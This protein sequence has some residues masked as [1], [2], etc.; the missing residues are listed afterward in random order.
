MNLPISLIILTLFITTCHA[1]NTITDPT[2]TSVKKGDPLTEVEA[3]IGD[4]CD[5][6]GDCQGEH[7]ICR[8]EDTGRV[9]R[10]QDGYFYQPLNETCVREPGCWNNTDCPPERYCLQRTC[11]LRGVPGNPTPEAVLVIVIGIVGGVAATTV[12][13]VFVKS[14]LFKRSIS[15]SRSLLVSTE[16]LVHRGN[17]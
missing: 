1:I 10:C 14:R 8:Q 15:R 11:V 12:S 5:K 13:V 2:S 6:D 17:E 3:G 4:P 7:L 9:C 16:S